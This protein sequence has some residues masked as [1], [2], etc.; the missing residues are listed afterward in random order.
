MGRVLG[1]ERLAVA[2]GASAGSEVRGAFTLLAGAR[3]VRRGAEP[4]A[5]GALLALRAGLRLPRPFRARSRVGRVCLPPPRLPASSSAPSGVSEPSLPRGGVGGSRGSGLSAAAISLPPSPAS[6]LLRSL[7]LRGSDS[8]PPHL[9]PSPT[10]K[11]LP[12]SSLSGTC[13]AG[14]G[15]ES[16]QVGQHHGARIWGEDLRVPPASADR[17]ERWAEKVT[18]FSS[19]SNLCDQGETGKSPASAPSSAI[20]S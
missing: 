16:R 17:G 8:L 13:G 3:G 15:R 4:P 19:S 9:P 11:L 10:F 2:V 7:A 18:S 12:A 6:G 5:P 1:S 14:P 20:P